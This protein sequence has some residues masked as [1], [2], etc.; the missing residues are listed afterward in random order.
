MSSQVILKKKKAEQ[1]PVEGLDYI[2]RVG[3]RQRTLSPTSSPELG[4]ES[5]AP[6]STT[7]MSQPDALAFSGRPLS[8]VLVD[9]REES[10]PHTN[11]PLVTR[12]R[13]KRSVPRSASQRNTTADFHGACTQ[14]MSADV[15]YRTE[16][17][18]ETGKIASRTYSLPSQ[19]NRSSSSFLRR[20]LSAFFR[21]FLHL[22]SVVIFLITLIVCF[23]L[24]YAGWYCWRWVSNTRTVM[25]YGP[26]PSTQITGKFHLA[27]FPDDA[28]ET[29]TATNNH[30][31]VYLVET[32][33]AV[34]NVA[35][36]IKAVQLP[37]YLKD[38]PQ[39]PVLMQ[40]A[41]G[42]SGKI[43]SL[44]VEVAGQTLHLLITP[45]GLELPSP[46]R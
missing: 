29:I 11:G 40:Y 46:S 5:Y 26:L 24:M 37:L 34:N 3:R 35:P 20:S 6:Q 8:D 4:P 43:P 1:Q 38:D 33:P 36:S 25:Q 27:G 23:A 41:P 30:G 14:R 13:P 31:I 39:A 12:A 32:A 22:D 10:E 19:K 15:D 9:A 17:I 2:A 42:H 7:I 28:V 21:W 18:R 44:T 16:E 45:Q